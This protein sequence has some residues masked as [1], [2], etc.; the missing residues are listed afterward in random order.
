MYKIRK[1]DIENGKQEEVG[2]HLKDMVNIG[3]NISDGSYEDLL[4]RHEKGELYIY[5]GKKI[6]EDTF[7]TKVLLSDELEKLFEGTRF[8]KELKETRNN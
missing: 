1:V 6:N 7:L 5:E 4:K 3:V 2:K 8:L